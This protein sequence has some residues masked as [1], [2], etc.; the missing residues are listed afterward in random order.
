MSSSSFKSLIKRQSNVWKYATVASL[1]AGST[2]Y[3]MRKHNAHQNGL[4]A[5]EFPGEKN[6][7]EAD[8]SAKLTAQKEWWRGEEHAPKTV[9][10]EWDKNWI[11]ASKYKGTR[12]IIL[13]RHGQYMNESA[14]D[15]KIKCLTHTGEKQAF[16]TGEYLGR[17]VGVEADESKDDDAFVVPI[18]SPKNLKIISS[19]MLRARQTAGIVTK[20]L[21]HGAFGQLSFDIDPDLHE[22]FPC[23]PS[24]PNKRWLDN[25]TEEERKKDPVR[26]ERAFK[27]YFTPKVTEGNEVIVLVNHGNVI[28]SLVCKALQVPEEAWLRFSVAN[29]SVTILQIRPN[30]F[31]SVK[32]IGDFGSIP[33]AHTTFRNV[34]GAL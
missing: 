27:R 2:M 6:A 19:D 21:S 7:T 25:I 5:E 10:G 20:A 24:P 32:C 33:N 16:Y 14:K 30:G 34:S 4:F 1:S 22:G 11:D 18:S 15:E 26:I 8:D 23:V 12:Y 29:G 13:V 17:L 9:S 3:L 28:R 31:V